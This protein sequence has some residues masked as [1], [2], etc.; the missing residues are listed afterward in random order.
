MD[1]LFIANEWFEVA[2]KDISSAR[3]LQ[4]M[5]PTSIEIFL[6]F[7]PQ[8]WGLLIRPGPNTVRI[9]KIREGGAL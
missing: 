8:A 4:N 7:N 9:T 3:Y 6:P 5:N 2:E 1:N